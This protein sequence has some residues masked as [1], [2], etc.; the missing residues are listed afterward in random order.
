MTSLWASPPPYKTEPNN[1]SSSEF[2]FVTSPDK[3][4]PT[5]T[6]EIA[7]A[8]EKSHEFESNLLEEAV[9]F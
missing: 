9:H 2:P 5:N 4:T 1:T 3:H 6:K 8:M 7:D